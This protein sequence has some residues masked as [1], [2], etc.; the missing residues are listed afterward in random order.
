ML[1]KPATPLTV[2]LLVA[3]VLL[4][5]SVISTPIVKGIPLASFETVDYGVFGYCKGDK[6]TNIHVGYTND[7]LSSAGNVDDYYLPASTRRSLSS[8]LIVHPVAALLT[9]ICL[10]MAVA[11]HFHSPSHSP[12]YLLALLILLLPTLLVTLLAFLVDILL[13]VPHL[14]WGGW[15]V[16]GA[17]IILVSC[18]VVTCAMRRTLVSRK[19]RKKRIAENAEMSGENFYNRQ[20]AG[21]NTGLNAPSI[22]KEEIKVPFVTGSPPGSDT[23]PTFATFRTTTRESDDDRTPLNS[24]TPPSDPPMS[25]GQPPA[26]MRSDRVPHNAPRDE[27]GNPLPPAGFGPRMRPAPGDPRLRNQ[28]SDGSMSSRGGAPPGFGPRGRGGYPPRGGYGRG[29]PYGGP[30]GPPPNARGGPMGSMRGG[31]PGM[32]GRGGY[33]GPPQFVYGPGSGPRPM[34]SPEEVE[35]EYYVDS[36]VDSMRQPS[37]GPI[38][39]AVSPDPGHVGQAIEMTPQPRR[40]GS[41]EPEHQQVLRDVHQPH[42][43]SA[44]GYPEPVSPS[45]LYS[46]TASYTPPR[47]GWG[48]PGPRTGPSPSPVHAYGAARTSPQAR[49]NSGEYF[50][51]VD[52]RFAN[53]NESAVGNPR[54]PSALTPG[55]G[56]PKS[57]EEELVEDPGS[58]T[59]SDISHFTSISERP[60]NPRWRPPPLPSQQKRNVLLENNPDFD[61]RAGMGRGRS[62]GVGG[63]M[64]AMPMPREATR[65]P[66]P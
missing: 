10:C 63:R 46:R 66:I 1:L 13:F 24:R 56:E 65:Y 55:N 30:R 11:A 61:L 59:T 40:V 23:G 5:L 19:A 60:V 2:L 41:A 35:P 48:Q 6:C 4:L 53:R 36:P 64:P 51:D 21:A 37:P 49:S 33:R 45:S 14:G 54:L 18:G 58:P 50:E 26:R 22:L 32:M 39:M 12:R 52:P 34:P 16:L 38:G 57:V 9:L 47:A 20:N 25:D 27:F 28:Y 42:A 8:I 17:T 44:D 43:L 62:A 29:G 15:I 3:F 7:D 31:H